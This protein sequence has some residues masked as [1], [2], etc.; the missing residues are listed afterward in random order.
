M[1]SR[2]LAHLLG[3]VVALA[4]P[5]AAEA[6]YTATSVNLRS[7]PGTDYGVILTLPAGAHVNVHYCQPSWCSVTADGYNGWVA[8]SYIGGGG[9]YPPAHADYPPAYSDQA[10]P[11]PPPQ[12]YIAPGP[13]VYPAPY[14]YPHPYRPRRGYYSNHGYRGW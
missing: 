10:Y 13:Y 5:A 9:A 14:A 11:L 4:V 6:A 7:G 1:L 8:A 2:S 12:V 3:T